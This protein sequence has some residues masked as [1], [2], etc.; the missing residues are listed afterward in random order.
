MNSRRLM[1]IPP[2]AWGRTLP[3]R[4]SEGAAVRRSKIDRQMAEMGQNENLPFG[5]LCQPPLAADISPQ[6]PWA[7]SFAR[8]SGVAFIAEL[9]RGQ[10]EVTKSNGSDHAVG[11]HNNTSEILLF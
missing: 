6:R 11:R 8:K 2:Q 3:H 10:A 4:S 1:G 9:P 7:H 5:L